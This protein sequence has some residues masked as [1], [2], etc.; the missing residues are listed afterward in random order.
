M[1]SLAYAVSSLTDTEQPPSRPLPRTTTAI[2]ALFVATILAH[3][4]LR[5]AVRATPIIVQIPL[6]VTLAIGGVPLL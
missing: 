4:A 1:L 5:F 2:A 3:L 6:L